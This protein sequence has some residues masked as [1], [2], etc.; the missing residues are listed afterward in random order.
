MAIALIAWLA[1]DVGIDVR[2]AVDTGSTKSLGRCGIFTAID[3]ARLQR[4]T[5]NQ[6]V[7]GF[8]VVLI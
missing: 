3:A 6:G 4:K 2:A 7:S 1:W 5:V 8:H